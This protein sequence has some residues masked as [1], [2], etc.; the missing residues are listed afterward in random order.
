MERN[1]LLNDVLTQEI[2]E[3]CR[4]HRIRRLEIFGSALRE[5]FGPDSDID[6]LIDVEPDTSV[7]FLTFSRMQRDLTAMFGRH[8]DPAPRDGLRPATGDDVLASAEALYPSR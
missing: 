5:D 7:G 2:A 4:R 6:L 8:V 1:V 3:F